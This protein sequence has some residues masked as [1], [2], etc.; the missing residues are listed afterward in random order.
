[1]TTDISQFSSLKWRNIGPHRGGRVVAVAGHPTESATFYF[2]AC[3]GGVWMSDDAGTYW[4]N[5]SD[6]YF[7][8]APVGA[9]AI[10]ESD[11]NVIFV[12]TGEACTRGNVSG[13]DGVYKTTD[14]GNTWAHLGLAETRHISRIRIHP[15][16]PD[17]AYVGALG[18]IFGDNDARGVY[19]TTDGGRTWDLVLHRSAGAGVADLTMDPNNPRILFAAIWEARRQP[20][21][22]SS[23]GPDSSLYRTTDGGST[24]QDITG[25]TGLPKGLK[26]RMGIAVSP[27]K[28]GR[29]WAIVEADKGGRGLYRSEDNGDNWERIND[30]PS[31]VQRPWYYCHVIG[32]P[33]DPETVWIMNLKCWKSVDG[34]RS[35]DEVSLPHGDHHDIWI[36]PRNPQRIIQ[37]NDGGA[38][39][40]LNGGKSWSTIYNQPTAQFYRMATDN[41]FPYRVYAT[42]QDNS[43][44]STPSRDMSKGAI[45]YGDSYFVGSSESGQIAVHPN[46]SNVVFSG[47]IGSSSGGGDSLH[48]Y[49]H[50]TRQTRIVSVWPEFVYGSGVKDHKHRFQWTYPIVFSPHDGQT[51]YVA[52][53]QV[54]RSKDEG[55]SWESISPDLTRGDV[56]KMEASGGPIT[57]DTTFVENFGTIFAFAESPVKKGVFWA[58][59]DDGVVHISRDGGSEWNNVTPPDMPE[60][61][62]TTIV[63]PSPY[64]DG[65]AYISV[66]RYRL[67]DY[68]PYIF[69]TSDYGESWTKITEGIPIDDHVWVVRSDTESQGLLYAGTEHGVYV[70]FN[71]GE[72]W[73]SLQSDLPIV[74]V[75]DM[76]VKGDELAIATHGRSFW[77]L[78]DLTVLRQIRKISPSTPITENH[79]FAPATTYRSAMQG[80]AGRS[81]GPG[82]KYM[83]RLGTAATWEETRDDD[84]HTDETWLDAGKNPVEGAAIHYHLDS[85]DPKNL[86]LSILDSKGSSV[87]T[88]RPKP[89]NYIDLNEEEKPDGPFLPTKAGANRLIWN[90]RY[91]PS[92]KVVKDGPKSES[93]QGPIV[94]PGTYQ[95]ILTAGDKSQTQSFDV[96]SDPRVTTS[97]SDFTEQFELMVDV[98]D[99]LSEVHNTINALRSTRKQVK[100]WV[101]RA[102]GVGKADVV[103]ETVD[104]LISS[105]DKIELQLIQTDAP[106]EEG[107][108]RIANTAGLNIKLKELMG[109]IES[110]DSRPTTQQHEVYTVFSDRAGAA[111]TEFQSVIDRDLAQFVELLHEHQIP[112]IVPGS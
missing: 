67:A 16:N 51:L 12:G 2:G 61:G 15:T 79:L 107:L 93:I 17:V 30:S 62:T 14:G 18:D 98:R 21:T 63:D 5:I 112:S 103:A 31:L 7:N 86:E 32:D 91:K 105:L 89:S 26:G 75:H 80:T 77:I 95:V 13:G 8:S 40:S 45:P 64:D 53:E 22:F 28:K 101:D 58:A 104:E 71:D 20:W 41:D 23:G 9:L 111:F 48:R 36:D 3:N 108:D 4:R 60:W 78:D 19:R 59:S 106:T 24:W 39:V 55:H 102:R 69:K 82:K 96:I 29:V 52:G 10:S 66:S 6:G 99:K 84:D 87:R 27:A 34:G 33:V 88:Y 83:T 47:A 49:D 11:P 85:E 56:T 76:A 81:T 65:C 94:P 50:K 90:L 92:S 37:G 25:N 42:Q 1:M 54:F 72:Q 109:A 46:D 44:I 68:K 73:H 43:A 100:Q 74:P 97:A 35:F 70:S 57:K 38:T 110:A